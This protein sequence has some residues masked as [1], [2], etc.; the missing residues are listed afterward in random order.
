MHVCLSKCVTNSPPE[1]MSPFPPLSLCSSFPK[2][3]LLSPSDHPHP[4]TAKSAP[5]STITVDV[6]IRPVPVK[7]NSLKRRRN[8]PH[9]WLYRAVRRSLSRRSSTSWRGRRKRG[10]GGIR[11]DVGS[12]GGVVGVGG[13]RLRRVDPRAL[14]HL[15]HGRRNLCSH[16]LPAAILYNGTIIITVS[17]HLRGE[18][19]QR[20]H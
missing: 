16:F 15:P 9:R 10:R 11:F 7:S 12:T 6:S 17:C 2:Q 19:T 13:W 1:S 4:T 3:A 8:A 5:D 18:S 20:R 14:P